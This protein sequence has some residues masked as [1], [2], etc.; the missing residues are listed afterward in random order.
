[1]I[2]RKRFIKL[3]L[4]Q[5]KLCRHTERVELHPHS[6]LNSSL[7]GG[8]WSERDPAALT[9]RNLPLCP[10]RM[11]IDKTH[12]RSGL[13][14]KRK[15][16]CT[17]WKSNQQIIGCPVRSLFSTLI[18]LSRVYAMQRRNIFIYVKLRPIQYVFII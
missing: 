16:I 10:L 18:T 7:N 6:F 17:C 13:L 12:S 3:Y 14:E 15:I 5:C 8:E 11:R 9:V 4:S 2:R 1:M